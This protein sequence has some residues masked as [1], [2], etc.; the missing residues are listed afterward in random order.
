MHNILGSQKRWRE[1]IDHIYGVRHKLI[2]LNWS[3]RH[4]SIYITPITHR[5]LQLT[6]VINMYSLSV[7]G[8]FYWD[9]SLTYV[10]PWSFHIHNHYRINARKAT[11]ITSRWSF[12][13]CMPGAC[14]NYDTYA[15]VLF[16]IISI[17]GGQHYALIRRGG[18][19]TWYT[20]TPTFHY[21]GPP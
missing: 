16:I 8:Q 21:R 3:H 17:V 14:Q 6:M 4:A 1:M 19:M 12:V 2:V 9:F 15:T 20:P 7:I 10:A 5:H 11:T 13:G 18:G